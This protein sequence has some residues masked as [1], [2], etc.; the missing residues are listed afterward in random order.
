M[1]LSS[2]NYVDYFER[3][4]DEVIVSLKGLIEECKQY[5]THSYPYD[6]QLQFLSLHSIGG[7]VESVLRTPFNWELFTHKHTRKPLV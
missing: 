6:K 5:E 7:M 2:I 4:D 3:P 1:N